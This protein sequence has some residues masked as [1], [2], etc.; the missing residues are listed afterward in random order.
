MK[1]TKSE[2]AVIQHSMFDRKSATIPFAS[3]LCSNKPE[4]SYPSVGRALIKLSSGSW[5]WSHLAVSGKKNNWWSDQEFSAG[6]R[7]LHAI[8]RLLY[9]VFKF[10]TLRVKS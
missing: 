4:W 5:I 7:P 2:N 10:N 1:F 6:S 9:I 8:P 3:G